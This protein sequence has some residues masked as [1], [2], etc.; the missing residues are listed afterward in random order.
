MPGSPIP[1]KP[2]C[3]CGGCGAFAD[4][5]TD[6]TEVDAQ[7]RTAVKGVNVCNHH[8]NWPHSDDAKLFVETD[9]FKR[10]V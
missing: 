10:R 8:S 4:F 9:A 7:G 5:S 3:D 1:P 6:G 2:R